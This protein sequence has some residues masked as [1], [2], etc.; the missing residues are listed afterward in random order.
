MGYPAD[1]LAQGFPVLW[2]TGN[3]DDL[4]VLMQLK[5]MKAQDQTAVLSQV[6]SS[7][8]VSD[9][10]IGTTTASAAAASNVVG[11]IGVKNARNV[12]DQLKKKSAFFTKS[13]SQLTTKAFDNAGLRGKR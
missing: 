6:E 12:A 3:I 5:G 8:T 1:A 9:S 4:R 13:F 7:G 10:P 2:P 11:G